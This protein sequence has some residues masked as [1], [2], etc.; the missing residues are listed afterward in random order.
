MADV[1]QGEKRDFY[2]KCYTQY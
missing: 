1:H 2:S